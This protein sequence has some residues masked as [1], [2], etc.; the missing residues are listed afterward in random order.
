MPR[1]PYKQGAEPL[2][3]GTRAAIELNYAKWAYPYDKDA[4]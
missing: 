3:R 4:R 1:T 2:D